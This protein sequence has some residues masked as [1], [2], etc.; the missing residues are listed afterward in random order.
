MKNAIERKRGKLKWLTALCLCLLCFSLCLSMLAQPT[1]ADAPGFLDDLDRLGALRWDDTNRGPKKDSFGDTQPDSCAF[2]ATFTESGVLGWARYRLDNRPEGKFAAISGRL[3]CAETSTADAAMRL[4]IY[5]EN[6]G[7]EPIYVS[8]PIRRGTRPFAFRVD[9]R[10]VKT[11]KME[12]V[13][14]EGRNLPEGEISSAFALLSEVMLMHEPAPGLPASLHKLIPLESSWV[15]APLSYADSL[16]GTRFCSRLGGTLD[17]TGAMGAMGSARYQLDKKY[18]KFSGKLACAAGGA[19]DAVMQVK[20]YADGSAS[21]FYTS[22]LI[23]RAT[24]P[25]D[26]TVSVSGVS[27]LKIELVGTTDPKSTQAPLSG[28]VLLD[29]PMLELA[30]PAPTTTTAPETSTT[31]PVITYVP[32]PGWYNLYQQYPHSPPSGPFNYVF[33]F[34]G[35]PQADRTPVHVKGDTYYFEVLKNNV[36][37][38]LRQ[39]GMFDVDDAIWAGPDGLFGTADDQVAVLR[40][41]SFFYEEKPGEWKFLVSRYD[42]VD[43]RWSKTAKPTT[44]AA[45]TTTIETTTDNFLNGGSEAPPKTGVPLSAGLWVCVAVLL[46]GCLYCGYR[47]LR[48][49]RA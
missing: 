39:N 49:E 1:F 12:L 2:G 9:L 23:K 47:V 16:N 26:F 46:M 5:G 38:A 33:S 3:A 41:G 15:M 17:A 6:E 29:V 19:D 8:D 30:P 31:V 14:I 34:S 13:Q 48:K 20:F 43:A 44:T 36:H 7:T 35:N 27:V 11:I 25:I 40:A 32:V 21:A 10:G 45:P 37:L 4:K 22:P 18:E 28:W 24:Q 42:Y